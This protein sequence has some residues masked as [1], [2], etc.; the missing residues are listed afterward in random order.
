LHFVKHLIGQWAEAFEGEVNLKLFGRGNNS[1]Y[2][3]H[4]LDGLLRGDFAS[5]M[6]GYATAIQN[7]IR[8]PDEVRALENLPAKGA[9]ADKL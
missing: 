5:R 4:N 7:A 6:T 9:D 3:E 2:V 1:R 8:T